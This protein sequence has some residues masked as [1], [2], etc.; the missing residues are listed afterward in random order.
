MAEKQSFF[1]FKDFVCVDGGTIFKVFIEFVAVLL[2]LFFL[3]F[4][5]KACGI[6]APAR[7]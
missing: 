6:L 1:Y 3:L 5:W 7:D 4:C 2:L